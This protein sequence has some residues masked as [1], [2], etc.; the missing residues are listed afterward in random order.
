VTITVHPSPLQPSPL[1]PSPQALPRESRQHARSLSVYRL[2][3]ITSR[4][5]EGFARVRNISDAGMKLELTMR[6][7]PGEV[8][9]IAFSETIAVGGRVVWTRD[10]ECGVAFDQAVDSAALLAASAIETQEAPERTLRLNT[11]LPAMV[12]FHSY[13][14]PTQVRQ[15]SVRDVRIT[16]DGSFHPGL[17][18][19]LILGEGREA[20]AVVRWTEDDYADVTLLEPF[21]VAEL[22][23]LRSF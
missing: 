6:L 13:R 19:R 12:E 18:V 8:I 20:D 9:D 23:S 21:A 16:H 3:R 5:D 11:D 1:Q 17:H 4:D 15:M 22:G 7:D 10:A 14:Q 2:V